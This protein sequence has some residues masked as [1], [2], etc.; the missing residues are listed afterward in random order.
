MIELFAAELTRSVVTGDPTVFC[1]FTVVILS[2]VTAGE[3]I[4]Y[5]GNSLFKQN[6]FPI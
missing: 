5:E 3:S 2:F 6:S 1:F 4:L